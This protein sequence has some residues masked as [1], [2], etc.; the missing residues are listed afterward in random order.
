MRTWMR[1]KVRL[2]FITCAV[3][4]AIPAIALADDLRNNIDSSFDADF[5]VLGLLAG[6]TSQDVNIV[7]QTQGGDGDG[8]CNLDG[9]EKIQV[10]AVSS[11]SAASVKWAAT[12][13]DKVE[14][15]GCNSTSSRNLTVTPGSSTGTANVT[16][17]IT[18]TGATES[19][20]TPG[21]WTVPSTGDGTYD[22][23]TAQFK[24]DVTSPNTPPA[25]SVTGVEHGA[26]YDKGAVPDAGCLVTDTE[27]GLNASTTAATLTT[28]STGLDSDGLGLETVE[29]S[30]TDGGGATETASATYTIQDPSAPVIGHTLNPATPDGS[31]GWYKG[32]VSLTW[33]VSEPQSPNSLVKTG[34]DDQNITADQAPTTYSCSATSSGGSAGPVDVTIKRDGSAPNAPTATTNPASPVANSGDFFADT[35]TVSYGGSTDVGPSGVASYTADQT[36]NTSGTHDYS[37]TATDNAGNE[38]AA[39]TGQVKVDAD[40][41]TFGNCQG[42]PFLVNSGMQ[43][44]SINASDGESGIASASTLSGSVNTS[45]TG[46]KTFTFTAKDKVGHSVTKDCTYNVGAYDF[47]GFS[48]P[49]DNH[50]TM[51]SAKAG[52]A[53]PLKWRLMNNGTPVTNLQSVTVTASSL[54]CSLGSS[55]DLLEEYASGS[56]GLQNLGDGYYQF[57]WKTPTTYVKS[58]KSVQ[59][60]GVGMQL[61]AAQQ[62]WFQFTK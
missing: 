56:S 2:L 16:F 6:G 28:D 11:S 22:V 29:C 51:N 17:K 61:T 26:T 38:S 32:N 45:T 14:F 13:N 15:L 42:G 27:D 62:P 4:L 1:G 35:V 46:T 39:T 36:F 54:T 8:G 31:N 41:P 19:T 20:T 44:V 47:V 18:S 49:V 3:L 37:G 33:N 40:D 7:L 50:P 60:N 10:Q 23:R 25:V 55:T 48:S 59:I 43:S 5:E 12:G 21:V 57:N 34:C 58:C 30:Y 24:V 53:I 52:Q 9:T